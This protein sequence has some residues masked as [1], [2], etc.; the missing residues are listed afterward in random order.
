MTQ[1]VGS[2][3]GDIESAL[4]GPGLKGFGNRRWLE[5]AAGGSHAKKDLS[6]AA[7]SGDSLQV[8]IESRRHLGSERQFQGVTGLC[9]TH[10]DTPGTP[11]YMVE[12]ES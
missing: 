4:S 3:E 7:V 10:P 8:V 1:T 11:F 5:Y 12:C 2:L 6:M 9:L